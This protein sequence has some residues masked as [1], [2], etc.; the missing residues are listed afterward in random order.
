M[1]VVWAAA[2]VALLAAVVVLVRQHRRCRHILERLAAELDV[3]RSR[4]DDTG[5]LD[6][7]AELVIARLAG[8]LRDDAAELAEEAA[9]WPLLART[10]DAMTQ[11]AVVV[12]AGGEIVFTNRFASGFVGGRHSD[13][14]VDTHLTELLAAARHGHPD[15][16]ELALYGPPRRSLLLHALPLPPDDD[17]RPTGAVVLIDD[18]TDHQRLD[19]I[20]RDFVANISH[21]LKTPIG[22]ISLLAETLEGEP[23]TEVVQRLGERISREVLRLGRTVEDLLEFSRIEHDDQSER[24]VVPLQDAIEDA[25]DRHRVAAQGAGVDISLTR[26]ATPIE[27]WADRRQIV[28]AVSNLVDNAIK[29]SDPGGSITI[30]SRRSDDT[31]SIEVRDTGRGIPRRDLD[32]VFERFYRVDSSRDRASGGVGLGLAIVRHVANNHG[33]AVEVTSVEGEGSVFTLSLPASFADDDPPAS[34]QA[35]H[36][37]PG[38]TVGS[39][40]SSEETQP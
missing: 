35:P 38:A 24:D 30:R 27:M 28:S 21:E 18:I 4:V 8:R 23:D 19:A 32:R 37:G 33:G 31:V 36:P 15:Q 26:P 14:V 29:Y 17:G 12:D 16:H 40:E 6:E 1:I 9:R 2:G 13:A 11:G 7:L 10:L 39:E 34:P 22:A 3:D 5:D 20:R 25:V